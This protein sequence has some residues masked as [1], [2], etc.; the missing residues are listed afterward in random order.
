MKTACESIEPTLGRR[1][2]L[3]AAYVVCPNVTERT[4]ERIAQSKRVRAD[5]L[6]ILN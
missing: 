4:T 6:S 1:R 3:F 2:I 5:L